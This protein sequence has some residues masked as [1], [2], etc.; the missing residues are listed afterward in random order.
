MLSL[1]LKLRK[2]VPVILTLGLTLQVTLVHLHD[3]TAQEINRVLLSDSAGYDSPAVITDSIQNPPYFAVA[4]TP[5]DVFF[6][7]TDTT[8]LGFA[9][10]GFPKCGTTTLH[11]LLDAHP[12]LA[13]ISGENYANSNNNTD[14][15][16]YEIVRARKRRPN[17]TKVGYRQSHDLYN[18]G[19]TATNFRTLYPTAPLIVTVRHPIS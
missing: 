15:L 11:T 8:I 17:A 1:S 13:T 2:A 16:N 3:R 9:I 5:D 12:Q 4:D 6:N 10:I 19:G 7:N 18:V 14:R